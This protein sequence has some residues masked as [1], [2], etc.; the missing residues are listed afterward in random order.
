MDLFNRDTELAW[1][2]G[3]YDGE[4]S[5]TTNGRH[6]VMAVGQVDPRPLLRLQDALGGCGHLNQTWPPNRRSRG[7]SPIWV[8]RL[9]RSEEIQAALNALW[10]YLSEPKREQALATISKAGGFTPARGDGTRCHRGHPLYGPNVYLASRRSGP[11]AGTIAKQC[12][13]CKA[14]RRAAARE[15][16]LRHPASEVS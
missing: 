11:Q 1:A 2:A 8:W 14:D 4:G 7:W 12:R 15:Y 5:T 6:V 3:F 10:P 13:Q 16:A 9:T